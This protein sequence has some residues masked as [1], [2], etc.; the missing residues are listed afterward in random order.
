MACGL[1][2]IDWSVPWLQPWRE[3][4][5]PIARQVSQGACVAQACNAVQALCPVQFVP[6]EQLPEGMPYEQY[7][8]DH[9]AVPTRDGLHDFFNA[10]CW[11]HF[12]LA[13][14]Q[15]NQIQAAAIQAQ[16]VGAVRGPV[17]DAV[18]VFDENACLLQVDDVI[19]DALVRRDWPEAFVT[20]RAQWNTAQLQIFGHAALEKLVAPYK[21]ITVHM[22]RVPQQVPLAEWDD[23]LA[24]DLQ[25]DKLASK[26]FLPTP[27][28]GIPGWWPDN[29]KPDFYQD[30][31]VFRLPR[32]V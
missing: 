7:I 28:L 13:K 14:K 16:G 19:W 20:H 15:L 9:A 10:L 29:E 3:T 26:P 25:T 30:K 21:A 5:E 18:T 8:F 22:W 2:R 27:V 31:Q 32:A 24:K 6:Q 11:L 12:P 4:G 17:R 1:S 23:W